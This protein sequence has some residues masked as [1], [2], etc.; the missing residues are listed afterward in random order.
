MDIIAKQCGTSVVMIEQ[1]YRHVVPKRHTNA[2][3]EVNL[4]KKHNKR[5]IDALVE[6][7]KEWER[8]YKKR[9]CI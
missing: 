9:G 2:L 8:E 3:S 6:H 1:H 5:S 7:L 4:I